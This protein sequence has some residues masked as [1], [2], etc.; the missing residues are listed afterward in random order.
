MGPRHL[1]VPRDHEHRFER[2]LLAAFDECNPRA[3]SGSVGRR[4]APVSGRLQR[5]ARPV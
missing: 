5:A 2:A 4:P 1:M 3:A